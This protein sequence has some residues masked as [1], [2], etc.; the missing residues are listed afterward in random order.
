MFT[1]MKLLI[2]IILCICL[3]RL[4]CA[5]AEPITFKTTD[6][7]IY[8]KV[9]ITKADQDG[10]SIETDSGIEKI[11]FQRLPT[12][13]QKK[14]GYDPAKAAQQAQEAAAMHLKRLIEQTPKQLAE[15]G[16]KKE[17]RIHGRVLQVI[18]DG[19]LV[20]SQEFIPRGGGLASIGGGGNVYVPPDPNGRG[21]PTEIYGSFLISGHPTQAKFADGDR[22]DVDAY[23]NGTF[24][25][26]TVLG[27]QRT[28]K[29]YI[30]VKAFE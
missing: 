6:G 16:E 30:V 14:F 21:R 18:R 13:L 15:Q 20:E 29:K 12:E 28:V 2:P 8:E 26:K 19:L 17:F 22:I 9:T 4:N 3:L 27:A 5:V 23:E 7:K 25:F 24:A 10:I 11:P 1:R